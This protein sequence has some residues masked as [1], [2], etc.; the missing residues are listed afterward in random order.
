MF[1]QLQKHE[2]L[3][4]QKW[5]DNALMDISCSV[6]KSERKFAIF[7]YFQ[8]FLQRIPWDMKMEAEA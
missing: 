4:I 5:R 7:H 3:A 8:S 2:Y 6:T 1:V